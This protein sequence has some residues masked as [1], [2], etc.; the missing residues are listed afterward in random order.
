MTEET[1]SPF[2][3]ENLVVLE[4]S[5]IHVVE[6]SS[7][8][9]DKLKIDL[10]K[11]TWKYEDSVYYTE[12]KDIGEQR[13]SQIGIIS[14]YDRTNTKHLNLMVGASKEAIRERYC[15]V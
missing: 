10:K 12:P 5:P 6:D 11:G 8:S 4:F 1:K 2:K 15:V 14:V 7:Y 9:P 3:L 13:H